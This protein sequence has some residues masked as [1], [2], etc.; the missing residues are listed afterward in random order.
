MGEGTRRKV[1]E[2]GQVTIPKGLREQFGISGGD[3]VIISEEDG[4]LVIEPAVTRQE[5]A[6]GYRKRSERAT[7]LAEELQTVS[8]EATGQV[9]DAPDWE[10][11]E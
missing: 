8:R 11:S 2:R 9:G 3:E 7:E 10:E 4:T 6:E 5:L 1:G